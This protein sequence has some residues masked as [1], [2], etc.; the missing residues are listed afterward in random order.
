MPSSLQLPFQGA[1]LTPFLKESGVIGLSGMDTRTLTKIIREAGCMN[2]TI[3]DDPGG[4]DFEALKAYRIDGAV[5]A[6]ST[7]EQYMVRPEGP[8]KKRIALLDFRPEGKYPA[9]AGE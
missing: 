2:G 4:V 9:G 1:A 7:K 8:V 3:T 5:K 6:S